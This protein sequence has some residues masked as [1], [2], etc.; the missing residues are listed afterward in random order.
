MNKA[1]A[2]QINTELG[3]TYMRNSQFSEAEE[4]LN[5]SLKLNP[6]NSD[7]L[8]AMALLKSRTNQLKRASYYY[9]QALRFDRINPIINNNYGQHL[10][11]LGSYDLGIKH[12]KIA[13]EN[14]KPPDNAIAHFNSG[15]CHAS[16]GNLEKAIFFMNKSLEISAGYAPALVE[17]SSIMVKRQNY[18]KAEKL[19][20]RFNK[21]SQPT[22]L[23]LYTEYLISDKKGYLNKTKRLKILLKNLFPFSE[24]NKRI[25]NSF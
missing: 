14:Y 3:I 18:D 6:R 1:E 5:K 12:L 8:S 25:S 13:I 9:K 15:I 19:I 22:A 11:T 10:C 20:E 24:E 23:S 16:S 7:A 21:I 4:K 17:L 2:V